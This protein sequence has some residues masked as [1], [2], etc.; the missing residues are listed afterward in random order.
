[1]GMSYDYGYP[2]AL[3][4]LCCVNEVLPDAAAR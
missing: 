2:R 3:N 4:A 1:M